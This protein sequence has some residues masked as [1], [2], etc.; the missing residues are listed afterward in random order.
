MNM[1][2]KI[3]AFSI[4]LNLAVGIMINGIV[5]ID[6]NKIFDGDGNVNRAG[7]DYNVNQT[8]KFTSGLSSTVTP[9]A[10]MGAVEDVIYNVLDKLN[11][12]F[13]WNFL[14]SIHDYMYGFINVLQGITGRF[15]DPSVNDWIFTALRGLLTVGYIIGGFWLWTGKDV[16]GSVK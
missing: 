10:D 11:I 12:G 13:I 15:M 9:N 6:G 7:L 8:D 2:F 4:V 16:F 3:M 14:S 1:V 5:D